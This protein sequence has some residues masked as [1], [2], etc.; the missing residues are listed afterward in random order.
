MKRIGNPLVLASGFFIGWTH[1]M[2]VSHVLLKGF[3]M[4]G[5]FIYGRG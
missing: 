3:I 4:Y 5:S 1:K 2:I